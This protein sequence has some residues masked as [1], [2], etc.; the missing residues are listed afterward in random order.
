[1]DAHR[2]VHIHAETE[3]RA[4]FRQLLHACGGAI[5]EAEI[6]ALVE[7]AHSERVHQHPL[8]KLAGRHVGQRL[9]E[10]KHAQ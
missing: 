6:A 10:G 3:F 7:A 2:R 4:E 9:V 5:P 8:H 1:M